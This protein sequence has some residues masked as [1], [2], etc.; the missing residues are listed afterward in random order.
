MFMSPCHT[1]VPRGAK[2]EII[3]FFSSAG[4]AYGD[5]TVLHDRQQKGKHRR[6]FLADVFIDNQVD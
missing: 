6:I 2:P 4:P 1:P 5:H 3:F